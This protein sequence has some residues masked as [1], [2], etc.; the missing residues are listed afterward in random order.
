M[1]LDDE[2]TNQW[3]HKTKKQRTKT[4]THGNIKP[5]GETHGLLNALQA[6]LD[7]LRVLRRLEHL[8]PHG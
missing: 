2:H 1:E 5:T 6:Q 7:Q 4:I 8:T 3:R